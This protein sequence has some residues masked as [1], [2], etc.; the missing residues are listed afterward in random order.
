[1][2]NYKRIFNIDNNEKII[3]HT[4]NKPYPRMFCKNE[5]NKNKDKFNDKQIKEDAKNNNQNKIINTDKKKIS[6][7]KENL[8]CFIKIKFFV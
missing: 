4:W 2:Q 7:I 6:S 3:I 8:T 1:M 5:N